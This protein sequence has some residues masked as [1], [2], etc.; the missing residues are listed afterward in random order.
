M[1]ALQS[2]L[3]RLSVVMPVR[4]GGGYLDAAL[5]S[6]RRQT[7]ADIEIVVVDDR[8]T[9]GTALLLA[10]HA[11][12]DG[13]VRVLTATGAGIVDALNQGF[14]EARADLVG[15]MDADDVSEPDRLARQVVEMDAR[16]DLVLLGTGAVVIDARDRVG[17]VV[18]VETDPARLVERLHLENPFLHP[19]VV[20]RR[21]AVKAAGGYRRQFA[22]AEDYDLWT[23]LTRQGAVANL[24]DAL[25]RLRRHSDQS[26]RRHRAEQRAVYAL[27]RLLAYG[28]KTEFPPLESLPTSLDA[29]TA[30]LGAARDLGPGLSQ[31]E[32]RDVEVMLRWCLSA[33]ALSRERRRAIAPMLH[34][35]V[36]NL[37]SLL[38][39]MRLRFSR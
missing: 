2:P 35:G 4:N 8:S 23:R 3:P 37:S 13:R 15:R 36:P 30:Y 31:R 38:L 9:D 33:G 27:A 18:A 26:S 7:F 29:I 10:R 24:P 6:I 16:P 11:A 17:E 20:M 32:R 28:P 22:L 5:A 1:P 14:A 34:G 25:H 21:D 12:E 39:Q 19:T